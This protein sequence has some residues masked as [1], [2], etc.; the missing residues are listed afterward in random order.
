MRT[1]ALDDANI[2]GVSTDTLLR[3]I[4]GVESQ[5]GIRASDVVSK[6]LSKVKEKIQEFTNADGFINAKDLYTIRKEIGNII[7]QNVQE[8]KNWDK[9]LTG[10]LQRDLQKNIDDSIEAAGGRG[11]KDYLRTYSDM[12]KPIEQMKAGQMLESKLLAPLSEDSAQRAH[13]YANA[14]REQGDLSQI[15]TPRQS[16]TLESLREELAR[17]AMVKEL[18]KRGMPSA[19]ERIGQA[20]PEAPP[21]GMFSPIISVARGAYNRLAGNATDKIMTDLSS[22]MQNPQEMARVMQSAKPFERQALVDALMKYQSVAPAVAQEN[23]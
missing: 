2:V 23:R 19:R 11:W 22:L 9:R 5:P 14:L 4:R 12:S 18:A 6:S 15:F 17:D 10:G 1:S 7:E 20:L 8:T 13:V 21:T 3:Q 16:H